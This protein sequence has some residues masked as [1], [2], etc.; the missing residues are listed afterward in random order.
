M[1]EANHLC[2]GPTDQAEVRLAVLARTEGMQE[3]KVPPGNTQPPTSVAW[4]AE[5]SLSFL[6]VLLTCFFLSL[7]IY[8]ALH[9]STM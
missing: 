3:H 9:Q 8:I 7:F 4:R 6:Q 1:F 2:R 5:S